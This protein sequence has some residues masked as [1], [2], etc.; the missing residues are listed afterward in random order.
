MVYL[1]TGKAGAGKTHYAK[2]FA[3]ELK[4]E[5]IRVKVIDGD[6]FRK[7]CDNKD[8]SDQGR[9]QNLYGAA[10]LASIY[11]KMGYTVLVSFIAPRKEWRSVMRSYWKE[12]RLVYLPGG[13]LWEGTT[14]ERPT[15]DE[16]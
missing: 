6:D 12:S 4:E 8:F 16:F 15:E 13:T 11:E 14:Y 7:D 2:A 10:S 5:G 9:I 1:I 3:K